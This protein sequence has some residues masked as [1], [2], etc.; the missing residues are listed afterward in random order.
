MK[1]M[2]LSAVLALSILTVANAAPKLQGSCDGISLGLPAPASGCFE[3]YADKLSK[4]E[5]TMLSTT[6]CVDTMAG[7]WSSKACPANGVMMPSEDDGSNYKS[8]YYVY[9]VPADMLAMMLAGDVGDEDE[10]EEAD[11]VTSATTEED[12]GLDFE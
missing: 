5:M 8:V 9:N 6:L 4:Q 1:K 10:S 11:A 12:N 7:K 2:L 3:V